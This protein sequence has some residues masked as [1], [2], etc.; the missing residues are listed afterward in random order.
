MIGS[1]D[2]EN[3]YNNYIKMFWRAVIFLI[4]TTVASFTIFLSPI[5]RAVLVIDFSSSTPGISQ[6]FFSDDRSYSEK[7][8]VRSAVNQGRN[9]VNFALGAFTSSLRWDPLLT[10]SDIE[11]HNIYISVCG[12]DFALGK[13]SLEPLNQI[14]GISI[15]KGKTIIR[16][17]KGGIDP[18]LKIA[19]NFNEINLIRATFSALLGGLLAIIASLALLDRGKLTRLMDGVDCFLTDIFE[20]FRNCGL[21]LREISILSAIGAVFYIY[22]L[23]TFSLSI[24]DEAAAVRVDPAVW[25]SQGRWFVYLV[26]KYVFPQ[27]AIP[28]APFILL[29]VS[30]AVSYSLVLRSHGISTN[31]KTYVTYC[32]FCAFPTWWLISEFYSNVPALAIGLLFVSYSLY[33]VFNWLGESSISGGASLSVGAAIVVMLSCAVAAYQSLLLLFLCMVF[34]AILTRCLWSDSAAHPTFRYCIGRLSYTAALVTLALA[35]YFATNTLAQNF[36]VENSGYIDNFLNPTEILNDPNRV[37]YAISYEIQNIYSG[38]SSIF[39]YNISL[40]AYVMAMATL[41][42]MTLSG[43]KSPLALGLW[44][45]VLLSP[46]AFHFVSGGM[47]LPMRSMI[48]LAYVSWLASFLVLLSSRVLFVTLGLGVIAFYQIQILSVSS[49]YIASATI[50]QE[51]DRILAADIY[52]RIGELSGDFDRKVPFE[53]DVYGFKEVGTV[54]AHGRTSATQG[55]FF[56][57]D[58]GNIYRMTRYMKVMG[59]GEIGVPEKI[60]RIA[61]TPIFNEMPVWPANGSVKKV[62]NRYLVR[63]GKTPDPVHAKFHQ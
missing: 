42:I 41:S 24:D 1:F 47:T 26:E 54:Y 32:S 34:G 52:R 48:S 29:V 56:A 58:Q 19:A 62:G 44:A 30:L 16:M 22:F 53:M 6:L 18:Q 9:K 39:G 15:V 46:F 8:S 21:S 12:V 33:L 63:L 55:S 61:M 43:R 27:S 49:Q 5:N 50:T 38:S 37:V 51:H 4:A 14:D 25:I 7:N 60:E 57:W 20:R 13:S 23:S 2:K 17:P 35:L 28:F 11:I 10:G 59:Y 3:T 45:G 31:W 36:I 40:T